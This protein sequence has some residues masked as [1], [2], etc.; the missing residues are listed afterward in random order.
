MRE[1]ADRRL[2]GSLHDR[3]IG[4]VAALDSDG[5]A[6]RGNAVGVV[7][8]GAGRRIVIRDC[9]GATCARATVLIDPEI[10]NRHATASATTSAPALTRFGAGFHELLLRAV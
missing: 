5:V 2:V 4:I 8:G 1:D 10:G 7:E 6:E 9:G 3:L